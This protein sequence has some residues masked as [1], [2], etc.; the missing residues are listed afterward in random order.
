MTAAPTGAAANAMMI[1]RTNIPYTS[2]AQEV[3]DYTN[4]WADQNI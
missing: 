2:V 3:V 4:Q 1:F